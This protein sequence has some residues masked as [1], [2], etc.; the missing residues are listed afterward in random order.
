MEFTAKWQDWLKE[1]LKVNMIKEWF[2]QYQ[3]GIKKH[4]KQKK[5]GCTQ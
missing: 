4:H 2:L 1:V 5:Y 3:E